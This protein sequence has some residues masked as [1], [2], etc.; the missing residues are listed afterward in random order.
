MQR[1]KQS[2]RPLPRIPAPSRESFLLTDRI[3]LV[4]LIV[5]GF[6]L[7]P[8]IAGADLTPDG[9]SGYVRVPSHTTIKY[10]QV[11]WSAH[12][13]QYKSPGAGRLRSL[14]DLAMGFSPIKDFE[15]GFQ[16]TLDTN[17][18]TEAYDPD[19][20]V[21]FKVRLPSMGDGYFSE[22]AIGMILDTNPN[23]YHSLYFTVGGFGVAWNFGGN[24]YVGTARYGTYDRGRH[25]PKNLCLIVGADLSPGVPG[26]RG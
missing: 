22:T 21:N 20:T 19:P 9:P 2:L 24:P 11:E 8:A 17:R 15:L 14:T 7:L 4:V 18:A 25:Q 5:C 16:K 23:N 1:Q 6:L 10:R 26:E 3:S 13:R 12:A